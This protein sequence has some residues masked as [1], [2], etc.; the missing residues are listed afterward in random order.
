MK[1]RF[2]GDNQGPTAVSIPEDEVTPE[3]ALPDAGDA[4]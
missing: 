4:A 1:A 3:F 2:A